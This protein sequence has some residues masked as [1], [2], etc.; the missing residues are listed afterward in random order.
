M[1]TTDPC[2]IINPEYICN[3]PTTTRPI[4]SISN[5]HSGT[6]N[7]GINHTP[8]NLIATNKSTNGRLIWYFQTRST[9]NT[10]D[11]LYSGVIENRTLK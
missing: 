1:Q 10:E 7:D 9:M 11:T 8:S 6:N 4:I 3:I 2:F 5:Y